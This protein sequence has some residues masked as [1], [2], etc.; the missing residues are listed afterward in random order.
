MDAK[1]LPLLAGIFS[2]RVVSELLKY[3]NCGYLSRTM[4]SSGFLEEFPA[5][6]TL[7]D[8]Y[9]RIYDVLRRGYRNEYVYKNAIAEKILLGR[10]S[11]NTACMVSEFRVHNC[12]ADVVIFN[13]TSNVYEIKTEYD[14]LDRL[15]HQLEA[16]LKVFD[17]VNVVTA[18]K[19]TK[20]VLAQAPESV[21][22]FELTSRYT[23]SPQRAATSNKGN[24][25][26]A[27]IFNSFRK[28]EYT[29]AVL[30]NFG[31]VPDVPNT[32]IFSACKDLFQTLEPAVAHDTMV[33]AMRT[34][35]TIK[36]PQ[37]NILVKLPRSLSA[38]TIKANFSLAQLDVLSSLLNERVHSIV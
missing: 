16:Y 18:Q 17:K 21:G 6:H 24:V 27:I 8:L 38:L 34:Y 2:T 30:D 10:H 3:G 22:V 5:V 20:K 9:T 13:G 1:H 29:Q 28:P 14:S 26:P 37:R 23:L 4:A 12:K 25:E 7:G 36:A 11:L 19:H 31:Y 15:E 35:R 33:R 32:L